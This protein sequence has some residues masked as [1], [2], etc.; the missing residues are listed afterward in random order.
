[1]ILMDTK[2]HEWFDDYRFG[3]W[4]VQ[5]GKR[6]FGKIFRFEQS[7]CDVDGEWL[8]ATAPPARYLLPAVG[9]RETPEQR[10]A[11]VRDEQERAQDKTRYDLIDEPVLRELLK[12]HFQTCL[13]WHVKGM[14]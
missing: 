11:R 3:I 13:H 8:L 12:V 5:E 9:V 2:V 1:M 10:E 14:G 6:W 7:K 4:P